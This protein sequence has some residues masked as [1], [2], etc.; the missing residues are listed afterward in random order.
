MKYKVLLLC[1]FGILGGVVNG[2]VYAADTKLKV[3]LTS[4]TCDVALDP[5][6]LDLGDNISPSDLSSSGSWST[7]KSFKVKLTD[8]GVGKSAK[9]TVAGDVI[10]QTDDAQK[11]MFRDAANS[12]SVNFGVLIF[13]KEPATMGQWTD[14]LDP[15]ST[16][17]NGVSVDLSELNN[18]AMDVPFWAA[19]TCG[20]SALCADSSTRS[21]TLQASVTFTFSYS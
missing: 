12:T 20:T 15:T 4:G 1:Y 18:R 13:S 8:C 9:L 14:V 5:Q 10:S 7:P 19:V 6:R 2:D 21:G 17:N 3:K 16:T 11:R